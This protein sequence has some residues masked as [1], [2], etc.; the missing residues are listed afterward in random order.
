MEKLN[1]R[2]RDSLFFFFDDVYIFVG[3]F[4]IV[5]LAG[6]FFF[7]KFKILGLLLCF[8][9]FFLVKLLIGF[10]PRLCAV[11]APLRPKT[12]FIQKNQDKKEDQQ[13]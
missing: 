5:V 10:Q 13:G 7:G 6:V 12:V 2:W 9:N 4:H 3:A 8:L 1:D 11:Q